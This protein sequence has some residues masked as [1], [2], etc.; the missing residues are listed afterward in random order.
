[1]VDS[2]PPPIQELTTDK[3]TGRFPQTWIRYFDQISRI[4]ED[5]NSGGVTSVN[6]DTGV[7]VLDTDDISEGGTNLYD[8]I[9]ALTAGS[10]VTITGTYPNFT[11]AASLNGS[12][13]DYTAKT[14][15]YTITTADSVID[16]TSNTF[17]VTLPTASGADGSFYDVK[18]SGTGIITLDGDGSETI[19][20]FSNI[21]IPN[22]DSFT[23][24]S[25]GTNWIII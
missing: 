4:I 6:G 24:L 2:F 15:N 12:D 11:I 25:N 3:N 14:A 17:T 7:V 23:V 9:V 19:D 1:M 13:R 16:C 5:L 10:N 8:K 21:Q 22:G 18:N 20:G